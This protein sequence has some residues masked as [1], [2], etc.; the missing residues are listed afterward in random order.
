MLHGRSQI[1]FEFPNAA[2]FD[3]FG[4]LKRCFIGVLVVLHLGELRGEKA[5]KTGIWQ[6][7]ERVVVVEREGVACVVETLG[8][9]VLHCIVPM[10]QRILQHDELFGIRI[11]EIVP[12]G[13]YGFNQAE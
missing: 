7:L 9:S 6:G 13:E 5:T 2:I 1:R 8:G 11:W 3:K 4:S 10:P 12:D